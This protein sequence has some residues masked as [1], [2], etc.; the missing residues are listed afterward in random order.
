MQSRPPISDHRGV[1]RG[2]A[3]TCEESVLSSYSAR[4]DPRR[5]IPRQAILALS[6]ALVLFCAL[7]PTVAADEAASRLTFNR[8]KKLEWASQSIAPLQGWY[9]LESAH[10]VYL[11]N[12]GEALV[13]EMR[14]RLETI[15]RDVFDKLFPPAKPI[16]EV[17]IVR[18]FRNE[19]EYLA[20]GGPAGTKGHWNRGTEELVFYD[21]DPL[22]RERTLSVMNA[23]AFM[24]YIQFAAGDVYADPWFVQGMSQYFAGFRFANGVFVC[25][26]N[27]EQRQAIRDAVREGEA[28]PL[29]KFLRLSQLEYYSHPDTNDAEGWALIYFLREHAPDPKWRKIPE[30]YFKTLKEEYAKKTA[31]KGDKDDKTE[32]GDPEE[33]A[34]SPFVD[35]TKIRTAAMDA[36]LEGI[37]VDA[38]Q[39]AFF[40][41]CESV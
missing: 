38:L 31:K 14:G 22:D 6:A 24:H 26:K 13:N 37:D 33:K 20:F 1:G 29:K 19:S 41:F 34:E 18:I 12:A 27:E 10:Y 36:A 11:S 30:I 35:E 21:R 9:C 3:T 28:P 15:R 39:K 8:L 25:A 32:K 5:R 17:P 23:I 40:S 2:S 7:G 16:T 4:S